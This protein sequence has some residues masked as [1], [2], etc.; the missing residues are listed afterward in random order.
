MR[1]IPYLQEERILASLG[2]IK[3]IST[4]GTIWLD[5]IRYFTEERNPKVS[6]SYDALGNQVI[7]IY[8][9]DPPGDPEHFI[10]SPRKIHIRTRLEK[11]E[12]DAIDLMLAMEFLTTVEYYSGATLVSSHE[13]F[14]AVDAID[15]LVPSKYAD[16]DLLM[17]V[18]LEVTP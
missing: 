1:W 17:V 2:T 10:K 5:D 14:V 9:T 12:L 7:Q 4:Y 6:N 8:T 15:R 18:Y 13:G 11:A 16:V 3:L